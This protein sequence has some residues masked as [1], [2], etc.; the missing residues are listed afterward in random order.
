[1][2]LRAWVGV[3]VV[4]A[5]CGLSGC[6]NFFPP[7]TPT[8][9]GTA[10]SGNYVYVV[11]QT[12][13]T[14]GAFTVGT[15]TLTAV[16]G[17]PYSLASYIAPSSAASV[18][19]TRANTFVYVGGQ[20]GLGCFSIG[21]TGAL[22]SVAAGAITSTGDFVSLDT[23]P[24]GKWLLALDGV[25]RVI[26]IYGVNPLTGALSQ[27]GAS[28]AY[29]VAISGNA[30]V[31]QAIRVSSN[32]AYVAVALGTGGDQIFP[33]TTS[34][35]SLGTP[36]QLGEAVGYSDNALSFDTTSAYLYIARGGPSAG[37][38]VVASYSVTSATAALTVAQT[39]VTGD[40]PYAVLIDSVGKY[41]YTANRGTGNVSGF[42][43]T[44]GA[45]TALSGSPY[46]SG[47]TATGL[48]EDNSAKYVVA[49]SSGGSPD[50]SVYSF[51]STLAGKLDSASTG[52]SGTDPAGA[53]AIAAT[54]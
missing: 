38:S 13:N 40:S 4:G 36:Q 46:S 15:A 19:V 37:K 28:I 39:V 6:S 26:N 21:T 53:I 10:G 44:A 43:I 2:N 8:S 20:G 32:A 1:M 50:Y 7:L 9:T 23:S 34:I 42:A 47:L 5:V 54:H 31:A 17:S 52:A 27:N 16:T 25:N 18:A 24:D 33:F 11:N 14:L 29:P 49:A 45:F 48:V 35:G 30:T 3:A 22:T 41:L 12:T 51:D